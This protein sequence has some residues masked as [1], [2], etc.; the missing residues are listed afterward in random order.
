MKETQ[1]ELVGEFW[2][3]LRPSTKHLMCPSDREHLE[4]VLRAVAARHGE[5]V[6]REVWGKAYDAQT[7]QM[8][9]K[10]I[11]EAA[12]AD[13]VPPLNLPIRSDGVELGGER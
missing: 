4:N 1:D 6:R 11:V 12:A 2:E 7:D 10:R 5:S 8:G 9:A 3:R 13:G